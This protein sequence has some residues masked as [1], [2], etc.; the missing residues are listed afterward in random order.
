M[1]NSSRPHRVKNSYFFRIL[2]LSATVAT[3]CSC[4]EADILVPPEERKDVPSLDVKGI[5][6]PEKGEKEGLLTVLVSTSSKDVAPIKSVI[7]GYNKAKS[8]QMN[9]KKSVYMALMDETKES[10]GEAIYSAGKL[11]LKMGEPE[12]SLIVMDNKT[13]WIETPGSEAGKPQVAKITAKDLKNQSRA[14]LAVL[15]SKEDTWNQFKVVKKVKGEQGQKFSLEPKEP[16]N[17]P[18]LRKISLT[19]SKDGKSLVQLSYEDEL[20]NKTEFAFKDIKKDQMLPARTFSYAP[21]SGAEITV[22][23]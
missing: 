2:V 6:E 18:D 21:P 20:E 1:T 12:N 8:V 17:W 19:L 9:V 23:E 13:I 10:E 5:E 11:R 15:F 7:R 3:F 22:Y 4:A 16:K 14:P